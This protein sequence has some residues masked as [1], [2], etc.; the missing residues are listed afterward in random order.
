M[1]PHQPH[2]DR[3]LSSPVPRSASA[4]VGTIIISARVQEK[5]EGGRLGGAGAEGGMEEKERGGEGPFG[6]CGL[7]WTTRS[8]SVL[9][10]KPW[11]LTVRVKYSVRPPLWVL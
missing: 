3:R 1:G 10:V 8:S 5:K 2:P 4:D 7:A 9:E 6:R 11:S